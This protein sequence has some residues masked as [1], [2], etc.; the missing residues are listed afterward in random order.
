MSKSFRVVMAGCGGISGAW[1]TAL[2]DISGVE[3]AGLMDIRVEAAQKRKDEFQLA[4]AVVGDDLAAMLKTLKPDVVFDCTLPEIHYATTLLALKQGCHV[5]GEKPLADSVEHAKKMVAAA[6]KARRVYAVMQNRRYQKEIRAYNEL[7]T[8]GK[9]GALT[10]LN[11]DFYIGAHFGGF[12][13]KMKHVLLLDMAIHTF[14]AARFISGADPVSVF[15]KEWNPKGS[16]Y[17]HDASAMAVFEMSN[18]IVYNYRGS[19]C[20]EGLNTTWECDWRAICTRGSVTWNGG[21][22]FRAARAIK[23]DGFFSK[24]E[25]LAVKVSP[26]APQGGHKGCIADFFDCLRKGRTPE[27]VCSDNI[28]SLAMVFGAI[29]SAETGKPVKIRV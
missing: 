4:G 16:W 1:L 24:Y 6:K 8:H 29:E 17:A 23:T 12:R 21:E 2:K 26:K 9:L 11:C 3:M 14:D 25:D 13:D 20:S 7:L 19:W 27:T 15:C 28:K 18:G 10:T 22:V 5:L